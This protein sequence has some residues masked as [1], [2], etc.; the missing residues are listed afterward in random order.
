MTVTIL[1]YISYVLH[2]ISVFS[3]MKW[4]HVGNL[5]ALCTGLLFRLL[6]SHIQNHV[7]KFKS[8]FH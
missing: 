3:M 1:K 8:V 7:V 6:L 5:N 4:D 2:N